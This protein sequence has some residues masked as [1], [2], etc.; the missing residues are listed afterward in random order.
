MGLLNKS[1][2]AKNKG[3]NG[4]D[5]FDNISIR[6]AILLSRDVHILRDWVL[7]NGK[8][9]KSK[10]KKEDLNVFVSNEFESKFQKFATYFKQ[11]SKF[12]HNDKTL[13]KEISVLRSLFNNK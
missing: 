12:I 10:A 5:Y 13:N 7:N 3:I 1:K 4:G 11:E 2:R 8:R 9:R 6:K